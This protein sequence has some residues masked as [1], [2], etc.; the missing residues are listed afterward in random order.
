[1]SDVESGSTLKLGSS[2]TPSPEQLGFPGLLYHSD[3][4]P[5]TAQTDV[6]I[7]APTSA[8]QLHSVLK[9]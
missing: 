4:R 9:S 6:I 1:M 2:K 7:T 3:A 8:E 5:Q